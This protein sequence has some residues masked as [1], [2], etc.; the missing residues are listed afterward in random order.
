MTFSLRN[1]GRDIVDIAE[2]KG[3]CDCFRVL[4]DRRTVAGGEEVQAVARLELDKE[5]QF[6]GELQLEVRGKTPSGLLAF[7]FQA[8]VRVVRK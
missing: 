4:I 3:S 5:P 2:V 8:H 1:A 7:A 6:T